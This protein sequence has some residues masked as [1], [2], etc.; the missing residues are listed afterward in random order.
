MEQPYF[1][2]LSEELLQLR[3]MV[4]ELVKR[5]VIPAR[6]ELDEKEEFP[7]K[8]LEKIKEAGLFAALYP[9][10]FG[11]LGLGMMGSVVMSEEMAYG[12]L[13][14]GTTVFAS[15]L[16]SLPIDIGGS[17]EQKERWLPPLAA[18]DKLGAFGLSEPNAGS[19]VPGMQMTAV[20]K[21]D[22]YILNGT[23]Q[24]ISNGGQADIYTVFA[25]T[26]K[27]RG[28][29]GISCFVVE[30]GTAGFSFGKKENKLG[31]RASETRQ[32]I[33]EDCEVPEEN[34]IGKQDHGFLIALNTLNLSRI[35]VGASG[36]G[37]AQGAFDEAMRYAKM[38]EQFGQKIASFQVIQHMFAD[39]AMKIEAG[40]LLTYK[41]AAMA[42]AGTRDM[43]MYSA[44]S[45]AFT[46]EAA[47][48]IA[49]QA[50]QVLGGYGYVKEYPVEKYFRDA[51][52]LQIYEGT[53]QVQKNEIA[54]G[55][56]KN[57]SR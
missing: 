27:N 38:R 46:A 9:E 57:A 31:I 26:N 52:I 47:M 12:C 34:L 13:G 28:P 32:L 54:A 1:F 35:S 3:D 23:K 36:V 4:R 53:T 39:M 17:Q 50:V 14:V 22:R 42:D 18:G 15:R 49:T 41:A 10:E 56:I 45:K 19:D 2:T 25:S 40:R 29:R 33:F 55:L 24:W 21:G 30:K 37:L 43:P 44:M 20:K 51:K 5:E 11:G 8:I 6:A 7:V 16:G 48:E